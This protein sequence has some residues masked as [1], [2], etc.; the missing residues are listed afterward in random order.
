M[1]DYA[2]LN[3]AL[4]NNRKKKKKSIWV[5]DVNVSTSGIHFTVPTVDGYST[6]SQYEVQA[7]SAS[8]FR[9]DPLMR[10]LEPICHTFKWFQ[11]SAYCD[12]AI[13]P[14]YNPLLAVEMSALPGTYA[15]YPVRQDGTPNTDCHDGWM[16]SLPRIE[17]V[18]RLPWSEQKE[19]HGGRKWRH[20]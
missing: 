8:M 20:S 9:T 13:T 10:G 11:Q 7:I 5:A 15:T 3:A 1:C 12:A 2:A 19:R 6:L 16:Q 18:L 4:H 17:P 14:A